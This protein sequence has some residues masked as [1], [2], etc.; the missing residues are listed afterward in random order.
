MRAGPDQRRL[1]ICVICGF[2]SRES[3]QIAQMTQIGEA[4]EPRSLVIPGACGW[5]KDLR[6]NPAAAWVQFRSAGAAPSGRNERRRRL[7]TT[8]VSE[9]AAIAAAATMGS[10]SQP[11]HG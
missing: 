11:V 10:S 1:R 7:L 3:P 5:W 8:T 2:F 6:R 4:G 9:E